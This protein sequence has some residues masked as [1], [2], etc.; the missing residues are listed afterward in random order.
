MPT[1][2]KKAEGELCQD[3]AECA[4][5]LGCERA[6]AV[7]SDGNDWSW[8]STCEIISTTGVREHP[9]ECPEA[10]K[11]SCRALGACKVR[12]GKCLAES[13][14]ECLRSELCR[15][16]GKCVAKNGGCVKQ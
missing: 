12:D 3:S 14:Y 13:N 6:H 9:E 15:T 11:H 10:C 7:C 8:A 16:E 1:K 4:K 2:P 5:G